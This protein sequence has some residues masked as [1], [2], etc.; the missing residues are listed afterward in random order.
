MSADANIT[1]T[2]E[3]I[4]EVTMV[5][6]GPWTVDEHGHSREIKDAN[7]I[8]ANPSVMQTFSTTKKLNRSIIFARI[9]QAKAVVEAAN[10]ELA[11]Q[12]AGGAA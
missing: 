9:E 7:G 2:V 3:G 10:A 5:G 6:T 1:V 11:K 4:G 12:S 8:I